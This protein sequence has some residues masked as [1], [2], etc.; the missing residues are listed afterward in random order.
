M[1][2]NMKNIFLI[3]GLLLFSCN[4]NNKFVAY[5][6]SNNM[7]IDYSME[8][9]MRIGNDLDTFELIDEQDNN[10]LYFVNLF[11]STDKYIKNIYNENVIQYKLYRID[12][13]EF[14]NVDNQYGIYIIF[15]SKNKLTDY[16][17]YDEEKILWRTFNIA[18]YQIV[19]GEIEFDGWHY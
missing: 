15:Y 2:K 10:L 1:G 13:I 12:I 16:S 8:N 9:S 14:N 3:L 19:N 7:D 6:K 18:L 11:E 5:T 4:E 17:I